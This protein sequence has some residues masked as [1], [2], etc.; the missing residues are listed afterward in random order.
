MDVTV[1]LA[2]L[3]IIGTTAG[4]A[5]YFLMRRKYEGEIA[6]GKKREEDLAS[7]I[8]EV[9]VISE[10][11][12]RIGY[13][14]NAGKIVEIISGSLGDLMPFSTVSHMILDEEEGSILFECHVNETVSPRFIAD[15]KVKMLAA[16]S[17]MLQ[18]PLRDID[19]DE[20]V[21]GQILDEEAGQAVR[22][23]FN[24]PILV[25]GRVIGLVNISSDKEDLYD[26]ANTAVL[27]RIASQASE[28][29][30][31]FQ[32][33]LESEKGKL[34]QAVE[35]LSD[36]V[37]MV[38]VHY[39]LVL[40]NRNLRK[41]LRLGEKVKIFDVVNALAGTFD[42]RT[43][44]EEA[45][46]KNSALAP[47]EIVLADRVLEVYAAGVSSRRQEKP[48]GVVVLFHDITDAKSLERLRQD[49]VAMM[50][51]ELR[52]PLTSIKSTIEMIRGGGSRD[53]GQ[54]A[55][56]L[57]TID[58]TASEML[59]L[60][61]DLL[62]VAKVEAGKF[63]IICDEGDL[64]EVIME[65]VEFVRPQAVSRN[66]KLEVSVASDLPRAWFDKVRMKQVITNLLSNAMKFTDQG[67]I[68]VKAVAR[69]VNGQPIDILVS[70]VDTGIGISQD[71]VAR[72][73][74]RFGQLESTRSKAGQKS[75][76]LGLY[77]TKKIVEASGGK[78]WVESA[79]LGAGSTFYFTVPLA[80]VAKKTRSDQNTTFG[81]T[82]SK[83]GQA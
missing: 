62:D 51:H 35:S 32:E 18:E 67:T 45:I 13:S 66:L 5:G 14:L 42:L 81:F 57:S 27:Y 78:V 61:N 63:D 2:T 59:D 1:S 52:A 54:I 23:F 64:T 36:G 37:L 20:R 8:Y 40:A 6:R 82:S 16:F 11:D 39:Q 15:V 50:V 47:F 22:S 83:V 69:E 38:D 4:I 31:K 73:F 30:S 10:I 48:L 80:G 21:A 56:Y 46:A 33:V 65:R 26:D 9:R 53:T 72:L 41:L 74:S 24:L 79:G 12:R 60:V 25:S 55:N 7:K 28:T 49:F 17:E 68:T 34:E 43:K 44:M 29:L 71:Q 76:G 70:V 3:T 77:I 58:S 75:S 19:I